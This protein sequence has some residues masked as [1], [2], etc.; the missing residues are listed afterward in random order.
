MTKVPTLIAPVPVL[1]SEIGFIV[2]GSILRLG[3]A[4]SFF[5]SLTV[6]I[7]LPLCFTFSENLTL[8]SRHF[9]AAAEAVLD[10]EAADSALAA[11][12][13]VVFDLS[14]FLI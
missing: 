8:L 10:E 2:S 11:F 5:F 14:T 1:G 13:T 6:P 7:F 3:S 12:G 4:G 9:D